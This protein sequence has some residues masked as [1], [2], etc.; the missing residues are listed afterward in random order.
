LRG[1]V[2]FLHFWLALL[3][4]QRKLVNYVPH[5]RDLVNKME[6]CI[7]PTYINPRPPIWYLSNIL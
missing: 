2:V 5:N 6:W 7:N 4:L 1:N 3:T